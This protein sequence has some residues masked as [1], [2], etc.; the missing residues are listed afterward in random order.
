M[1]VPP[2]LKTRTVLFATTQDFSSLLSEPSAVYQIMISS[3]ER[4][5]Q[6]KD[7]STLSSIVSCRFLVGNELPPKYGDASHKNLKRFQALV[8]L[9]LQQFLDAGLVEAQFNLLLIITWISWSYRFRKLC[10]LALSTTPLIGIE[11]SHFPRNEKNRAEHICLASKAC[12]TESLPAAEQNQC[13][14]KCKV[15]KSC[16]VSR[17]PEQISS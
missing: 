11:M 3:T 15:E 13:T 1:K 5:C 7:R 17:V 16:N 10:K 8:H 14:S 4:R 12:A 2:C 6:S 9:E